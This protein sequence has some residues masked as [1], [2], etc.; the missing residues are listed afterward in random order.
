M[1][2]SKDFFEKALQALAGTNWRAIF[3][4]NF[5]DQI[6][7]S[8]PENVIY[9]KY[10]PFD[11]LFANACAVIH[12]GGIGTSAQCLNAG[13]PQLII[14]FSHDQ[15]DNANRL[16]HLGVAKEA[17]MNDPNDKWRYCLKYLLTS[18]KVKTAC[19][20]GKFYMDNA[21]NPVARIADAI[22][23]LISG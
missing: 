20:T 10:E 4:S 11:L 5:A 3:V 16:R 13:K 9:T 1:A 15:F 22:E 17:R 18:D 8:L 21:P 19:K 12:H 7:A 2:Q 6:P 23:A 14:P